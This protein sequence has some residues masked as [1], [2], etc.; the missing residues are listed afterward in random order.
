MSAASGVIDP[1][2]A[3]VHKFDGK[4]GATWQIYPQSAPKNKK[5]PLAWNS[6]ATPVALN[7]ST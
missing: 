3:G 2:A 5:V 1:K 6:F 7:D 4:G